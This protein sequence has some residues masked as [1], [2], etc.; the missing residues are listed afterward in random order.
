[1]SARVVGLLK[2]LIGSVLI[3]GGTPGDRLLTLIEN[4]ELDHGFAKRLIKG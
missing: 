2:D 4:C 1:M 3:V